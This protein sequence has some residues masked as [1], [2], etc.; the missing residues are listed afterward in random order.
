MQLGFL[1][2][3]SP[4]VPGYQFFASYEAAH[5]VGGDYYGFLKLPDHR[6]AISLGDVSGKG[7]PAA[8]LMAHLASD[9]R[10][11]AVSTP[12]PVA[13]VQSVNRSLGEVGLFD[14]FDNTDRS[15]LR[16]NRAEKK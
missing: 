4:N 8:L 6:L 12:D 15:T 2:A 11:S 1:P 5:T 14:R 16:R 10:F 9:I 3:G 13:V 7:L